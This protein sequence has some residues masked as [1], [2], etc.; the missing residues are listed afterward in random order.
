M[1]R[2]R[3]V[4]PIVGTVFLVAIMVILA[5]V[6]G[7]LIL[8]TASSV[9]QPS[10]LIAQSTGDLD[11]ED[12][13]DGGIVTV[14]HEGGDTVMV[15]NI[16]IIID[17]T[18]TCGEQARVINLPAD[19][20]SSSN[21]LN[22]KNFINGDSSIFVKGHPFGQEEWNIGPLGDHTD[23]AFSTGESFQLRIGADCSVSRGDQIIVKMVHL[24]SNSVIIDLQVTAD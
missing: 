12:S 13:G 20:F 8:S 14:R 16:E 18:N 19:Y 6:I 2:D 4:S 17:A 11:R 23:D 22:N 9:P 15:K 5:T 3:G 24:P 10:P 7:G 21:Q 1:Y